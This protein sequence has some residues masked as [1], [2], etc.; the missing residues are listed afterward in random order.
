[1]FN[2]CAILRNNLD[3]LNNVF[4]P[5]CCDIEEKYDIAYYVYENDSIDGTKHVLND[6][7]I[8][9]ELTLLSEDIQAHAYARN[10]S[11]SRIEHLANCR[12]K[13]LSMRPFKYEWTVLVDSDMFFHA[14]LFDQFLKR[15]KPA[16]L[17]AL[18]CNG[19]DKQNCVHHGLGTNIC[20]HYYD[21]Y[22][23]VT[24]HGHWI[25]NQFQMSCN[26]FLTRE[27]IDLW[28]HD[29]MVKVDSA[30]GGVAFYKTEHFNKTDCVYKPSLCKVT[31]KTMSEH[32]H[33]NKCLRKYGNIYVDPTLAVFNS[34]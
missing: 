15:E 28:N 32:I 18:C 7:K 21:T 31:N 1:M 3:W 10:E 23:M 25:Y 22:A 8:G 13:L 17:V 12:N 19:K 20:Q 2:I 16:D 29:H 26:H 27:D 4:I 33:F 14:S 34:E 11:P 30:F 9:H 5:V 24:S 6:F